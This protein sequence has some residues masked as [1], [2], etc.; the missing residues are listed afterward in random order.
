ME[1]HEFK[2][3]FEKTQR[4]LLAYLRRVSGDDALAEDLLDRVALVRHHATCS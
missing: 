2:D 1:T 3:F 4:P